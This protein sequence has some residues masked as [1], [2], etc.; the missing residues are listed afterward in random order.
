[1][2]EYV[3]IIVEIRGEKMDETQSA[4]FVLQTE[5]ERKIKKDI[6]YNNFNKVL[7]SLGLFNEKFAKKL[8]PDYDELADMKGKA[9][10]SLGNILLQDQHTTEVEQSLIKTYHIEKD[11]DKAILCFTN[12]LRLGYGDAANKLFSIYYSGAEGK[13][14]YEKAWQFCNIGVELFDIKSYFNKGLML[15]KGRGVKQDY[16]LARRCFEISFI[17][18]GKLGGYELG[19][20]YEQALGV[21]E[22]DE[23][24]FNYFHSAAEC[25]DGYA[26]FK[27]GAIF[28]GFYGDKYKTI[29]K[30]PTMA[31]ECFNEY[32]K[33]CSPKKRVNAITSIG[34][35]KC[36]S[37]QIKEKADGIRKLVRASRLGDKY[38]SDFLTTKT[39]F[40]SPKETVN[41]FDI[42]ILNKSL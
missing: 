24:A 35:I 28:S 34:K 37:N 17:E 29:Q 15:Y 2:L 30:R 16:A 40:G 27:L 9:F 3:I 32:L 39:T 5:K 14:N 8:L 26:F 20:M 7:T 23:K 18:D 33:T 6:E 13:T 38:A 36:G 4:S 19:M 1:M 25:G 12:A 31:I 22:D 42:N 21:Q 41:M 11:V 10:C